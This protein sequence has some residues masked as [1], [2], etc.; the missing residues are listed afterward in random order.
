MEKEH[1]KDYSIKELMACCISRELSDGEKIMVVVGAPVI[2]AG[3]LLAHLTH[4]PNMKVNLSQ[5][6]VNLIKEPVVE[7][8]ETLTDWRAARWAESYLHH[9]E[10][11]DDARRISD[12]FF[13]G[14]LQIDK[15]GNT[16]LI[17]I[18]DDYK[19]LKFR[20][21]GV[22]ATSYISTHVPRYY[23]FSEAHNTRIFVEKC[24]F[25][26][27]FGWGE[28]GNHRERLKFPGGG[29]KYVI[30]SLCIMDFEHDSKRMRLKSLHPG[31][32]KD[33]VIKNTGFELIVDP[34]EIPI[35]EPPTQ[36]EI[37][38]LRT[39]VDVRGTLRR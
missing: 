14:G 9:N 28:G 35:T 24:D 4:G 17:G 32:T 1:A 39:R 15:F 13:L 23:L 5:V 37:E 21:P 27:S 16:N 25:I 36:K 2:R 34:G 18:G 29:P 7:E 20:G 38:V 11:Y 12:V 19:R 10:A 22:I 6:L 31:V 30:T 33:D 3:I 8:F 26:S